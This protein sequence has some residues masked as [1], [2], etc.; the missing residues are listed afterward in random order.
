MPLIEKLVC[1]NCRFETEETAGAYM[2]TIAQGQEVVLAHPDEGN[3]LKEATGLGW[4]EARERGLIRS[5]HYCICF[6]CSARVYLDI[7]R[8]EKRCGKCGSYDVRT[9]DGAIAERCPSCRQGMLE[10]IA[11]G[12]S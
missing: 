9:F 4:N 11:V 3:A 1:R 2:Y 10:L 12:V 6:S 7:D 5:K 8:L